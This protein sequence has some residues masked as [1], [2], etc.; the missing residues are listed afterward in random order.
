MQLS[1]IMLARIIR[2]GRAQSVLL[3]DAWVFSAVVDDV[4]S[5]THPLGENA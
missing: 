4:F 2:T 1:T 5:S 3:P